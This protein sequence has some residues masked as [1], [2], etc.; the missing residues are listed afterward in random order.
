[1]GGQ[2]AGEERNVRPFVLKKGFIEVPILPAW[3]SS[4]T[5]TPLPARSIITVTAR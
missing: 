1:M 5:T 4:W 3:A 2:G